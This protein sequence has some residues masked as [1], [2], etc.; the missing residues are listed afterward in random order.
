MRICNKSKVLADRAA[1]W[2][3][4]CSVKELSQ[5][6]VTGLAVRL[7]VS[8]E[9]LSRIFKT[10]K[11]VCLSAYIENRKMETAGE[12]LRTTALKVKDIARLL[13]YSEPEYFGKVFRKHFG[14]PPGRYR[15]AFR[16]K[17]AKIVKRVRS[18]PVV[19]VETE[20]GAAGE[21]REWW[22]PWR[23]VI[24]RIGKF[25]NQTIF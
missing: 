14:K 2:V 17:P 16:R 1:R 3:N 12:L 23:R 7:D 9:H 11:G 4:E 5:V 19:H 18:A 21:N 13:D 20:T 6:T 15:K 10:Q 24:T 25:M 22:E 8:Q